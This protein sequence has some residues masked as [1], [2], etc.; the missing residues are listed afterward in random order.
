M[1]CLSLALAPAV[2]D[3]KELEYAFP[4]QSVWTTRLNSQGQPDNPL[5]RLAGVL[6]AKAGIPWHGKAYPASRMFEYLRNGT[7]E[8]SMLVNAPALQEC[9]LF[10]RQPMAS[11]E[12]RVYRIGNKPAVHRREDLAGKRIITIRGY[13]YGGLLSYIDDARNDVDNEVA[14]KH[15]AAFAML[16]AGR[17]DYVLDYAGPAA[18]V[19][20]EHPISGLQSDFLSRQEIYLVLS[21]GYPDA[22]GVMAR[23]E[24]IADT[25]DK[26]AII[27]GR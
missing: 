13:S 5:L 25:L 20:A 24:A 19:L 21:R 27:E 9:C 2:V 10:G 22:A 8:F 6:F 26:Q 3:A 15:D 23:L 11:A 14:L 1:L 7:A 18:E 4:D 16:A 12:I 17:A